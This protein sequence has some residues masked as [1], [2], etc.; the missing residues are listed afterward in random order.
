ME[1]RFSYAISQQCDWGLLVIQVQFL[2]N[3]FIYLVI[4]RTNHAL[5]QVLCKVSYFQRQLHQLSSP[6]SLWVPQLSDSSFS[7]FPP[8]SFLLKSPKFDEGEHS[9]GSDL[10][11]SLTHYPSALGLSGAPPRTD[12]SQIYAPAQTLSPNARLMHPTSN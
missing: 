10:G 6:C 3:A 8:I 2:K 1:S 11:P 4:V 12:G 7:V 9:L 5:S